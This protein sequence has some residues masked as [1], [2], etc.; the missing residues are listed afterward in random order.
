MYRNCDDLGDFLK[1]KSVAHYKEDGRPL[2]LLLTL[3]LFRENVNY[4]LKLKENNYFGFR[5]SFSCNSCSEM[6]PSLE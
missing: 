3:V 2:W 5:V 1:F 4:F 6:D